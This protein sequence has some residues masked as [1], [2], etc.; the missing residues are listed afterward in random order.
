M[1]INKVR[2][3]DAGTNRHTAMILE[4]LLTAGHEGV[5]VEAQIRVLE[6]IAEAMREILS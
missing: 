3:S 4:L 1:R 6:Q 5:S 2:I